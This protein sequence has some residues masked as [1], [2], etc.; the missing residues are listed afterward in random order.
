MSVARGVSARLGRINRLCLGYAVV[1]LTL[2]ML[3]R[4]VPQPAV[5]VNALRQPVLA[6]GVSL[7]AVRMFLAALAHERARALA[8]KDD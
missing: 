2:V 6:G 7:A 4:L 8:G 3:E 1:A 5:V